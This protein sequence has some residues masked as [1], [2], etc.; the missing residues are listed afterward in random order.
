MKA[1]V[2]LAFL[3]VAA[4]ALAQTPAPAPAPDKPAAKPPASQTPV[5][6]WK[7]ET[8]MVNANCKLSGEMQVTKAAGAGLY[9]CKFVSVQS[10]TGKPPLEFKVQQ[11]CV[12]T[13]TG[14]Q[15][16]I[17]SKIDKVVSVKPEAMLPTVRSGYAPDNFDVTMSASG[18]EMRGMFHSLGQAT[19]RFWRPHSDLV[20]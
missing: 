8:G 4:P 9:S 11:S 18:A 19:V 1:A 12:A 13:Q 5:G 14:K 3:V 15:V 7:F 6:P 16:V 10:C 2:A 20:S 17:T